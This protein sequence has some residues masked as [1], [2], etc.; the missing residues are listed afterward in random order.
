[1]REFGEKILKHFDDTAIEK[2]PYDP[3]HLT[4]N[5]M[6][7]ATVL[8][9]KMENV[10]PNSAAHSSQALSMVRSTLFRSASNAYGEFGLKE[11]LPMPVRLY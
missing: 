10:P 5:Q 3:E 8:D 1:V 2:G 11:K 4:V 9:Y 7:R 6:L